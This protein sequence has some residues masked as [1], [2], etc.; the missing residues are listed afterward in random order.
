MEIAGYRHTGALYIDSGSGSDRV[1]TTA[2]PL[3]SNEVAFTAISTQIHSQT[4]REVNDNSA[5]EFS[6]HTHL[7]GMHLSIRHQELD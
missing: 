3:V 7:F 5:N 4:L 2:P 6:V 1:L